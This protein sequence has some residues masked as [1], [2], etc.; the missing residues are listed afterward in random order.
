MSKQSKLIGVTSV[1]CLFGV[2]FAFPPLPASAG[3]DF[4]VKATYYC[5]APAYVESELRSMGEIP[6]SVGLTADKRNTK[7]ALVVFWL[8]ADTEDWS[9]TIQ[10]KDVSCLIT[11]GTNGSQADR[12][13]V[14]SPK[15]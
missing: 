10:E 11:F 13:V 8:N 5:D 7:D 2:A 1:L 14:K 12:P 9:L 15:F 3:E 4:E 6:V